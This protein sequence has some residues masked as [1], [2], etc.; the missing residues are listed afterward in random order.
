MWQLT[1]LGEP[2]LQAPDGRTPRCEGKM[3]A[4]LAVLALDGPVSR[5]RLAGLLWPDTLETGARNNLVHLLRRMKAHLGAD[6]VSLGDMLSLAPE[7]MVDVPGSDSV[8]ELLS[9]VSWPELPELEDWLLAQRE[10]LAGERAG[11]WREEAQRLED[12]GEWAEALKI[13]ARLRALYPTSEDALRR[14]MRLLYLL[15]EPSQALAVYHVGAQQ[16]RAAFGNDPLPETRALAQDI[17]RGVKPRHA[18]FP[19]IPLAQSFTQPPLIGREDAWAQMEEAWAQGRGIVLTGEPGVGK[20]RLALDFLEAHGGGMRFRGCLG[21]AGL[22]YATHARTYRQVLTAYPALDLPTWVWEELARIL[23][24]LG[25]TPEP[26][27]S[28]E[29]RTRFWQ[30][31]AETLGAAIGQGLRCMVFDDTQFMDQASI[32]AGAFVFAHLGWG[33]PGAPYRTIHCFREGELSPFQQGILEAMVGAGLVTLVNLE[34]LGGAHAQQLAA[35]LQLPQGGLA[36]DLVH[37]TGGNP[38]LLLETARSLHELG[39]QGDGRLP[40]PDSAGRVMASRLTRLSSTAL[41]VARAAAVLGSDFDPDLIAQV[42]GVPL[43]ETAAAWEEL[44]AAQIMRGS[45]FEHDLIAEAALAG[46]P[47]S[48]RRLLHR[49][50]ARI[51]AAHRAPPA[52]VARHWKEGGEPR[53]A[54][55]WFLQAAEAAR[56]AYRFPEAEVYDLEAAGALEAAGQHGGS[57]ATLAGLQ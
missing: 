39:I 29:Q 1:L 45:S 17:E 7:V 19:R 25:H 5:S 57:R 21:D 15:G 23:P 31:K 2:R 51:L 40:L 53:E 42:L 9:G 50:A 33:D 37:Y 54:A 18:S 49:S 10:R 55:P 24:Q 3:L 26:I 41:H 38:L 14:E 48:V 30:A 12:A 52:L 13:V 11:R 16:L 4:T 22:P 28:D 20:T 43:L 46:V 47:G 34:P 36:A 32:E 35:A 8:G 27:N 44:E 6:L 56:G